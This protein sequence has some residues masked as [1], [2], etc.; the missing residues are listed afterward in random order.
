MSLNVADAIE[1]LRREAANRLLRAAVYFQTQHQQRLG[2]PNT[3]TARK[4]T[5]DTVAGKKGS[6]YTVYLNPSRPAEY[7]HKVTGAGQANV[8]YGPE[9]QDEVAKELKVRIGLKPLGGHLAILEFKRDRLGF[10]KSAAELQD[11]VKAL[12]S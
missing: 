10:L 8:T 5:R 9:T 11:Q 7:P 6:Q 3:G 4:R 1:Q 12:L 2:V